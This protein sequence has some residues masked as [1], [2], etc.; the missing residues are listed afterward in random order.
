MIM[1][2]TTSP[3]KVQTLLMVEVIQGVEKPT[4][5]KMLI[6]SA[7]HIFLHNYSQLQQDRTIVHNT[8]K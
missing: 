6:Q 5:R 3:H 4:E 2:L 1:F 7:D 8:G